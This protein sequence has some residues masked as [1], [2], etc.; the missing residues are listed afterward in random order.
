MRKNHPQLF[1]R[2]GFTFQDWIFKLMFQQKEYL[3]PKAMP[4]FLNEACLKLLSDTETKW[5]GTASVHTIKLSYSV[6]QGGCSH[7]T[8]GS[9]RWPKP[10]SWTVPVSTTWPKASQRAFP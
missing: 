5:H 3:Y 1:A 6:K 9:S 7:I 8:L 10:A 2:D 4:R